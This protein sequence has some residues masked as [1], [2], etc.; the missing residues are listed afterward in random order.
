ML[1]SAIP[2]IIG[3]KQGTDFIIKL[4]V[5]KLLGVYGYF[6]WYSGRIIYFPP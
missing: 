1:S 3:S 6:P 2:E 5:A 4:G